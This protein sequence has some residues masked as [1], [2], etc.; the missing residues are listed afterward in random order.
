Y[1]TACFS[2]P[3][4]QRTPGLDRIAIRGPRK[5]A[6]ALHRPQRSRCGRGGGRRTG[7]R[8]TSGGRTAA[9]ECWRA[10]S[11]AGAGALSVT[12][13]LRSWVCGAGGGTAGDDPLLGLPLRFTAGGFQGFQERREKRS[14]KDRS[15]RGLRATGGCAKA[16]NSHRAA[17]VLCAVRL[18]AGAGRSGMVAV[19]EDLE[20]TG[21]AR[22]G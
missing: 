18:H 7:R 17:R 3:L 21:R 2:P 8:P 4:H 19:A 13:L 6:W 11:V 12:A 5:F 10:A 16:Q 14:C 22:A 15:T 1:A 20:R 9:S